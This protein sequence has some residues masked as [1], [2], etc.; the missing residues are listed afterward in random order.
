M[1]HHPLHHVGRHAVVDEP[2]G[3]G[4]TQVVEAEPARLVACDVGNGGGMGAELR[5]VLFTL[6]VGPACVERL[7]VG[8]SLSASGTATEKVSEVRITGRRLTTY[9]VTVRRVR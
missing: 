9:R 5:P 1:A 7:A 2:G 6:L 4:V 8:R 3:V